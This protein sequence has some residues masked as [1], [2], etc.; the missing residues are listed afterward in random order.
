MTAL[1][2]NY[3]IRRRPCAGA[4][5]LENPLRHLAACILVEVHLPD[6]V[7]YAAQPGIGHYAIFVVSAVGGRRSAVGGRLA[8]A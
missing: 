8:R 2:L 6:S 3:S 5:P 4:E 1:L 7:G